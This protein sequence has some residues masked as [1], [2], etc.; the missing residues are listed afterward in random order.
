VRCDVLLSNLPWRLT[1]T[2]V[3]LLPSLDFRV[4]LVTVS[5]IDKL[6]SLEGAFMLDPVTV[7]E[8][9]DFWLEPHRLRG[10]SASP[11]CRGA[12]VDIKDLDRA[13]VEINAIDHA[14]CPPPCA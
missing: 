9:D 7:L 2:L 10:R 6:V 11:V 12:V 4:T 8:P 14:I 5:S 3:E 1:P 13:A